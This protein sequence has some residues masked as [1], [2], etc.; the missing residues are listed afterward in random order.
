[1]VDMI[2]DLTILRKQAGRYWCRCICGIEC[3]FTVS[4][5]ETGKRRSCGCRKKNRNHG[6]SKTPTY[7]SWLHMRGRCFDANNP[8]YS[9]WGGRGITVCDRWSDFMNFLEDMGPRPD[10]TSIDRMDNDGNYEPGNCRWATPL[11]QSRNRRP[12]RT[13]NLVNRGNL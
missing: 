12:Y 7:K 2:Y 1:M 11:E 13:K 4:Q 10:G 5:I 6:W 8:N 3:S 9:E